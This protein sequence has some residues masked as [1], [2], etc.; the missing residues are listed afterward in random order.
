MSELIELDSALLMAAAFSMF[1]KKRKMQDPE[2]AAKEQER[3]VQAAEARY[4]AQYKQAH[5]DHEEYR[6]SPRA[7]M[8][9]LTR[10]KGGSE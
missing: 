7:F 8:R 5:I 6:R 10:S 3:Q 9:R 4:D 2:Y 1:G